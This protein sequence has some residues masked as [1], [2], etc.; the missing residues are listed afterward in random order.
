MKNAIKFLSLCLFFLISA[1][2]KEDVKLDTKTLSGKWKLAESYLST[3]AAGEWKKEKG[4][5]VVE[6]RTDGT[7]AG[8]VYPE[9]VSYSIK[10]SST[11][12]F[13]KKDNSEQSYSYEIKDGKLRM[14]PTGPIMCIEGCGL[15]FVKFK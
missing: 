10:D 5:F 15:G 14:S 13:K 11:V 2:D 9:F 12:V 4:E 1:C 7:L 6:F 3:G 8:N